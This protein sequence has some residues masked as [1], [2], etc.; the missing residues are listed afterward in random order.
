MNTKTLK[1]GDKVYYQVWL[2]T[3]KFTEA[4]NNIQSVGVTDKYDDS[5]T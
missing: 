2:D 4:N 5:E 3:T 1:K